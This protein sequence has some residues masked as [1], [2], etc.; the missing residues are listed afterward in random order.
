MGGCALEDSQMTTRTS[1]RTVIFRRPFALSGWSEAQPA[2]IYK[3]ETEEELLDIMSFP[4]YRRT[5]TMIELP[6]RPGISS[7]TEIVMIDPDELDAALARDGVG[8][9]TAP[10]VGGDTATIGS[11]KPGP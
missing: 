9:T 2:G 7:V 6:G 5:A 4:A 11:A 8:Q 10:T 1:N 3:V